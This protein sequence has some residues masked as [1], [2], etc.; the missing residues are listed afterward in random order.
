M[1]ERGQDII[2]PAPTYSGDRYAGPK[3]RH[4]DGGPTY[5]L[6]TYSNYF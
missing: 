2:P 4:A 1:G 6:I 5:N 3:P